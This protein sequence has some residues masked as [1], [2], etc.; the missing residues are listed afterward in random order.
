MSKRKPDILYRLEY[1]AFRTVETIVRTIPL[2]TAIAIAQYIGLILW[3]FDKRHRQIAHENLCLAFGD[4][5]S[6]SRRQE[7][8]RGVF[9]HFAV[10]VLEMIKLPQVI[11]RDNWRE[12]VDFQ[13]S[14]R[15]FDVLNRGRGAVIATGH[16]GNFELSSYFFNMTEPPMLAVGRRLNNPYMDDYLWA[17]RKRLGERIVRKK[18]GIK[19]MVR[20]LRRGE[21][22]G[23]VA[24]QDAGRNGLFVDFFGR[25]AST[26]V[27]FAALAF[28]MKIPIIPGY[29]CRVGHPMKYRIYMDWPI[30]PV[31]TGDP[32]HDIRV[33]VQEFN[34]RLEKYIREFPEQ[35]LWTHRRWKT[36]PSEELAQVENKTAEAVAPGAAVAQ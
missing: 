35:W 8:I 30:E 14:E 21:C 4:K 17:N 10:M 13:H 15:L 20:A 23:F 26:H 25:K 32:D 19:H 6:E 18:G 12:Y 34:H 33:M 31:D 3:L 11:R 2:E 16:L 5:M 7:I 24:D 1:M 27:S 22:I 29:S 36:R 9:Q 28:R